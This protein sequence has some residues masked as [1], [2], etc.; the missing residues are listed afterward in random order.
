[1]DQVAV[2]KCLGHDRCCDRAPQ[3]HAADV[4]QQQRERHHRRGRVTFRLEQLAD[5]ETEADRAE[6]AQDQR[7]RLRSLGAFPEEDW[8][9]FV[10][11]H[12]CNIGREGAG[13]IRGAAL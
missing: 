9:V 6:E 11:E 13:F 7:G 3:C 12:S 1:M 8:N 2:E 10:S 4:Q 5:A